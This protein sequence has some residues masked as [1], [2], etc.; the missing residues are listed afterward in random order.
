MLDATGNYFL[1]I[2]F[3]VAYS[4]GIV[5]QLFSFHSDNLFALCSAK[6][7]LLKKIAMKCTASDNRKDAEADLKKILASYSQLDPDL[8]S[9]D[10]RFWMNAL[11]EA[12]E[13]YPTRDKI[14]KLVELIIA[15]EICG[16][17]KDPE[18]AWAVRAVVAASKAGVLEK[19][20]KIGRAHV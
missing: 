9:C 8:N 19:G 10:V 15:E 1:Q 18:K 6:S 14:V 17:E 4:S 13:V 2:L 5:K 16:N 12:F 7:A 11:I 20:N 3:A